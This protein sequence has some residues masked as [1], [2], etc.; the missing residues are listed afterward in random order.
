MFSFV[1]QSYRCFMQNLAFIG[2][3]V[4]RRKSLNVMVINTTQGSGQTNP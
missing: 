4:Q 2:Q 3:A 1:P